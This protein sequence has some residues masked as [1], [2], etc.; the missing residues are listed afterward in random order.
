MPVSIALKLLRH[1]SAIWVSLAIL[2]LFSAA[3]RSAQSR[4]GLQEAVD[5]A[6]QSRASLKAQ[7]ERVSAAEGFRRQAG[8]IANPEFQFENQNLRPGQTYSQDVDTLA[9]FTQPLDVCSG[10]ESNGLRSPT[11]RSVE[12]K[13]NMNWRGGKSCLRSS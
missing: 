7:A 10:S 2:E 12:R 9:I 4:L 3:L 1:C 11:N 8:A 5:Q 6:L 13:P